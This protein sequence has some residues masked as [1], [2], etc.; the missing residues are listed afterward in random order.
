MKGLGHLLEEDRSKGIFFISIRNFFIS[1]FLTTLILSLTAPNDRQKTY[2]F[3]TI[4]SM[5]IAS[6][7]F[8]YIAYQLYNLWTDNY[9]RLNRII[10]ILITWTL[11]ILGLLVSYWLTKKSKL[12]N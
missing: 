4:I 6:I 7:F 1:F 5:T 3:I 11:R 12:F 8:L 10:E 9:D 2:R